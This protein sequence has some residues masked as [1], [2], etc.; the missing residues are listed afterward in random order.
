MLNDNRAGANHEFN[1]VTSVAANW[2]IGSEKID[3]EL[4]IDTANDID[5]TV[6]RSIA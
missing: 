1:L 2:V 6:D 4:R 3:T 5:W